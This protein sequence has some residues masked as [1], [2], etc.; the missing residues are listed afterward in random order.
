M[1]LANWLVGK[2]VGGGAFSQLMFDVGDPNSLW[3]VFST[4]VLDGIRKQTEQAPKQCFLMALS[5]APG[6]TS[7]SGRL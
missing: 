6:M 5:S 3:V 7:L 1:L 4:L 2:L